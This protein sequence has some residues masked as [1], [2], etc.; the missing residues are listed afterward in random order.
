MARSLGAA[1]ITALASDSFN[2]ATLIKLDFPSPLRFTDWDRDLAALS[3]TWT[4]SSH[5]LEVADVSE[6][7]D[8]K[9]GS[10]NIT[11]SGVEQ[12]Y[13]S[14]FLNNDYIDVPV[15]IY[16]A[17]IDSSDAVVGTPILVYSG[18]ITNFTI[19]DTETESRVTV[20]TASHWKDFEKKNG[21]QTNHNTQQLYFSGDE[22][23]EY[24][25]STIKDLKWGRK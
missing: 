18:L 5:L 16:R 19:E 24:A 10:L 21:R 3:V 1:T 17:V 7:A 25:A 23:F 14:V 11:L 4:S 9:V 6:S 22:G 13:I 15:D 12:S 8:L 20:E 2:L